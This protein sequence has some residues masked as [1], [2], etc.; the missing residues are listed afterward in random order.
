MTNEG[1]F[2]FLL[3]GCERRMWGSAD[4]DVR[5]RLVYSVISLPHHY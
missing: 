4:G 5:F 1:F 2:F 3:W